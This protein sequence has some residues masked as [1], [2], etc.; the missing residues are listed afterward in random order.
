[1]KSRWIIC[2]LLALSACGVPAQTTTSLPAPDLVQPSL[3]PASTIMPDPTM[4][5]TP[6]PRPTTPVKEPSPNEPTALPDLPS[7]PTPTVALPPEVQTQINDLTTHV[8]AALQIQPTPD[9]YTPDWEL[10]IEGVR[11]LPLQGAAGQEPLW[12]VYPIGYANPHPHFIAIYTRR[13]A[14]WQELDRLVLP[15]ENFIIQDGWAR[16]LALPSDDLW[17]AVDSGVGA[18]GAAYDL[19]RW[20]GARLHSELHDS[21]SVAV[22]GREVDL[23]GDGSLDLLRD[24]RNTYIFCHACDIAKLDYRVWR[25]DGMGMAAV[26]LTA[27]PADAPAGL[28][29]LN[30]TAVRFAQAGL[31]QDAQALIDQAQ[32]LDPAEQSVR[33]NKILIDLH[34]QGY[35]EQLRSNSYPLLASMFSGDYPAALDLLRPYSVEQIFDQAH[36][37]QLGEFAQPTTWITE[38]ATLA[39]EADPE[40]AAAYF[41]RGWAHAFADDTRALVLPDLERAAALDPNEPLF[42]ESL[43][44]VRRQLQPAP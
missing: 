17:L 15:V 35:R 1:M 31:W 14:Q 22:W 43:A 25:W 4:I 10:Q 38:T 32:Q 18:H 42:R 11:A 12:A 34:V 40:R 9:S 7:E 26:Q 2:S 24:H 16:Q 23:D 44:L 36:P 20:D 6:L 30:D 8:A 27:L 41:L 5:A 28:R 19:L 13:Q 21:T 37:P 39:L 33:W 3:L 29:E